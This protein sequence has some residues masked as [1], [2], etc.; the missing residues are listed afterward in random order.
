MNRAPI[1]PRRHQTTLRLSHPADP[2]PTGDRGWLVALLLTLTSLLWL[3]TGA[4]VAATPPGQIWVASVS[5]PAAETGDPSPGRP[6]L[7]LNSAFQLEVTGFSARVWV[8]Q[9][10]R[11]DSG[12]W[13]EGVY[14]FPLPHDAA[15]DRLQVKIGE[16]L[17]EGEIQEKQTARRTYARARAAGQSASLLSQ[18]RPNEFATRLANLPPGEIIEVRIGFTMP[19][20]Y[21]DG[22]FRLRLPTTTAARAG[23]EGALAAPHDPLSTAL[24]SSAATGASHGFQLQAMIL[25]DQPLDFLESPTHAIN[26]HEMG[27][28]YYVA[29]EPRSLVSGPALLDRDFELIWAPRLGSAPRASLLV[30]DD[31]VDRYGLLML[32]PPASGEIDPTPRELIYVLDTSGSM[33]G[34]SLAQATAAL[35]LGLELLEPE[36]RFNVIEFNSHTD[37]LYP[38]P[39]AATPEAVSEAVDYVAALQANGGTNMSSALDLALGWPAQ[40]GYLR[41]VVFITDGAVG[42]EQ[43]VFRQIADRLGDSRLFTVGIGSAPNSYFMRKAAETGR[44][45]HTHI[46]RIEDVALEMRSLWARIRQPAVTDI[47]VDWPDAVEIFPTVLP[48]LYAGEPIFAVLRMDGAS[49]PIRVQASLGSQPWLMEIEPHALEGGSDIAQLWARRKIEDLE[50][51]LLFAGAGNKR[52]PEGLRREMLEVAMRYGLVTPMTSLVAVDR[53]PRRPADA[54]LRRTGLSNL[55]PAGHSSGFLSTATGWSA[56]LIAGVALAMGGLLL[57]V[58]GRRRT[59][60][61]GPRTVFS[62]ARE[63]R[64]HV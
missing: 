44:G 38:Q 17:I 16:R 31:G 22:E 59:L 37:S 51:Q 43:A 52:T 64:L 35:T 48:D 18:Q 49:A 60:P 13:I 7:R 12:H 57:L 30:H 45:S 61:V 34:E 40:A 32:Q 63:H 53:Q 3:W 50:H 25:G 39:V 58:T 19:V 28:G 20:A 10:F 55:T 23:S 9:Q 46:S 2:T 5:D 56:D 29:L 11:N 41:Q 15:V 62:S 14:R 42:Y 54:E 24:V 8:D 4:A 1:P 6:L 47:Q 33:A 36:D 21:R 26:V 27:D